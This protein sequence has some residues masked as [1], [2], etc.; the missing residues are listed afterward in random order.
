MLILLY[1][2][3]PFL[4]AMTINMGCVE[5]TKNQRNT[6]N[7]SNNVRVSSPRVAARVTAEEAKKLTSETSN[8]QS[9]SGEF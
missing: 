6:P 9:R 1:C 8:T 5:E 2:A 4:K 7:W 3:L